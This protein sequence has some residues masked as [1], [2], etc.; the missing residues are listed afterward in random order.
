MLRLLLKPLA[1]LSLSK[2]HILGKWLGLAI[3]FASP[4]SK[5]LIRKNL[6]QAGFFKPE[7]NT[8][9]FVK[10]NLQE[11]GKSIIESL[12]IWQKPKPEVLSW[13]KSTSNWKVIDNAIKRG[14]GIIFLTPHMGCF[15]ITSLY[16]GN[17]HPIT[18]LFRPPKR[19][20]LSILS[21]AGR[22]NGKIKQAPANSS[23][24]RLL[25]QALKN[26]E[27]IGIL[28]DQIPAKGEGEWAPFFGQPAYTMTLVSKLANKTGATV[29]MAF[30]ERLTDGRGFTVHLNELIEGSIATSTML[31]RAIEEQIKEKPHQYLWAYPRYKIRGRHINKPI[32]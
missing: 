21:A 10:A 25:L 31:N 19:K 16:Y 5:N 11:L 20:W 22:S 14:K 8:S 15:E 26:G 4:Y 17:S 24:V 30:G 29:I 9:A 3:Y 27:A 2:L 18:I 1:W 6:I 13:V 12:A 7:N 23:G 32:E 28:P